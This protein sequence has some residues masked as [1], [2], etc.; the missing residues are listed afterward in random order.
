M[1]TNDRFA[2]SLTE[3]GRYRMLIEAI[4]DYAIY[5]LQTDGTVSSWNAGARRFKGYEAAEIVGEN[6]SRFYL[7]EDR[8]A[9]VPQRALATAA[10][11]GRFEAEGWRVRKDGARFWAH[12]IIDPIY[13]PDGSLAGFAKITRDLTERRAAFEA[14]QNSERQLRLLVQ[15]VS[16]YAIYMLD[17]AGN[18][19]N[20][21][22]GAERIKGYGAEEIVGQHFSKFYT[23]EDRAS[24]E[25]ERALAIA[26]REGRFEKEGVRIRKD[27]TQFWA[28]VV[29][30]AIRGESG[31]VIGFAKVTRDITERR[32]A[33]RAL[34]LAREALMQS[35]KMEAIG[36]LTGGVAHDFNN[37]LMAVLGSLELVRRRLP[38]DARTLCLLDN[39]IQG[40]QR[41]VTLTQRML[42]F[43]RRQALNPEALDVG[44]LLRSMRDLMERSLGPS[45]TLEL[46][47]PSR[48]AVVQADANQLELALLNLVTNARDAM[49]A[50]GRIVV[51][52]HEER[53]SDDSGLPAGRYARLA[54]TDNGDGM[55]EA[56]LARCAEPFFTTKG[57]GHGTGLGLSM[58]HGMAEQSGGRLV[59]KSRKGEGTTTEIW[60]PCA[61]TAPP[62]APAVDPPGVVL[63]AA[64]KPRRL[65]VLA[66]DDD[67]LVLLNTT[68]MLEELGHTALEA[69]S[70]RQALDILCNGPPIDLLITD[71]AMPQMTGLQLAAAARRERPALPVILATGYAQLPPENDIDVAVLNKP[72]DLRD[73]AASIAAVAGTRTS[74]TTTPGR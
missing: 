63:A 19:T 54:V 73:L 44:E 35:Q 11:E 14:M 67:G 56:T 39:A 16:D 74:A 43:A 45:V 1:S 31:E 60:L 26:A 29:I 71:Q 4:Y 59:V 57:V 18:V 49:P 13:D 27:G 46:D 38:E 64:T 51:A 55:D 37:L 68:M 12:V 17:A 72:F 10:R 48:P 5:M 69:T 6:F 25:P 47:F 62:E 61:E 70:G 24:G 66:V 53:I 28:S 9:G 40:A 50:G 8:K 58:V 34:E 42:A 2:A 22:L 33:Q 15:S 21:N 65:T 30:D 32:D 3:D 20:W 41:G 36:Q 23:P 7:E 52:A